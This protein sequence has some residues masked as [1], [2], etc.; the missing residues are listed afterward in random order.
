[1]EHTVAI[2]PYALH[3]LEMLWE[4]GIA[5][6]VPLA[7]GVGYVIGKDRGRTQANRLHDLAEKRRVAR[8]EAEQRLRRQMED[9]VRRELR[10][11]L[12]LE[13]PRDQ[14]HRHDR[15]HPPH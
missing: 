1:M 15:A 11:G 8:F 2:G 9:E 14:P 4:W 5:A 7:A 10:D 6:I 12:R 3:I 13:T